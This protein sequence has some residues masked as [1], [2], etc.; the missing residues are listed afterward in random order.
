MLRDAVKEEGGTGRHAR[1]S[2]LVVGGKTGTAQK[3]DKSGTYGAGRVGSFVGMVPIEEPRYLIYVLLDE[4]AGVQYGGVIATPVFRDVAL[5]AMAYHGRLPDSDDPLVREMALEIERKQAP[6]N[7]KGDRGRRNDQR[8]LGQNV[9]ATAA[10]TTPA[11][12]VKPSTPHGSSIVPAVTGMGLRSAVEIFASEGV[13]PVIKGT[14][15][16]VVRQSP[17]PGRPWPDGKRE[18]ILWLEERA[19]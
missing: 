19:S 18:C 1:I 9:V 13:V 16:I 8:S 10:T 12:T 4:P 11:T 7:D 14:G 15:G 2:G 5:H 17:E 6:N 3:A